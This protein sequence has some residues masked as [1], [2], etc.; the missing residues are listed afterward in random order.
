MKTG[1]SILNKKEIRIAKDA[2]YDYLELRGKYLAFMEKEEYDSIRAELDRERISCIG[3]NAY[4]PKEIVIAGPGYDRKTAGRYAKHC[5]ER[6]AKLGVRCVGIGSP[7]S[8]KL[9]KDYS[10]SRAQWELREF[11]KST[12]DA[13]GKYE[14]T[15]CLEPLAPCY[16]NFV[17]TL[18]EAAEIVKE[19]GWKEIRLIADYYNL[20]YVNEADKDMSRFLPL[21][22]HVHMSDDDGGPGR[23]SYL[24]EEKREI[25]QARIRQLCKSGYDGAFSLEIDVPLE[26]KKAK[27]SCLIINEAVM[28]EKKV[29]EGK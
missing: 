20:E 9:P 7:E 3:L 25:H 18:E 12:A 11:L 5:A 19:I 28:E 24:R 21:L 1:C 2:G 4:C 14:I 17:N 23:R 27:Q 6:A 22:Y 10:L 8:R 16:C 15:V 29:R 26:R 13:F